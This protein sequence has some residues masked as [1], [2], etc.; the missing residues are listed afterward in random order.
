LVIAVD[1]FRL[2]QALINLLDNAGKY[3]PADRAIDV[4]AREHGSGVLITVRD[5]RGHARLAPDGERL[6]LP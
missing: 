2:E 5:C 6:H 4:E 1:S 3:S